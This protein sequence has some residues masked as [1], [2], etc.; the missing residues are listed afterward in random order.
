M[1]K[2]CCIVIYPHPDAV[3]LALGELQ[4]AGY[5]LQQVSVIGKG[6]QGKEHPVGFYCIDDR[7]AFLGQQ[8]SFW[9]D[10]WSKLAGAA[11]FWEPDF[12]SLAVAGSI[13]SMMIHDFEDI[14]ISAGF[15][16]LGTALFVIGVP[17][18]S[19]QEYE[20]AIRAENFLLLFQG[21]RQDVERVCDVL[22]S[23]SHQVI[24]HRA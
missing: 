6:W 21:E 4:A 15:S 17:R 1:T 8:D 19:I 10:C 13:V 14:E 18:G 11:F 5:D 20:E 2:I 9:P 22:H 12:G 24:V 23:G 7:V 16:L 3:K